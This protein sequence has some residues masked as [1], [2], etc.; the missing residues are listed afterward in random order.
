[1][2]KSARMRTRY[3]ELI[4]RSNENRAGDDKKEITKTLN[5]L[6]AEMRE[7]DADNW[8]VESHNINGRGCQIGEGENSYGDGANRVI[9]KITEQK[10]ADRVCILHNEAVFAIEWLIQELQDAAMRLNKKVEVSIIDGYDDAIENAKD[11]L[12][13]IK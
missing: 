1:M 12:N 8:F 9:G 11:I 6:S 7:L 4:A 2:I 10:D 5:E 13:R 3:N